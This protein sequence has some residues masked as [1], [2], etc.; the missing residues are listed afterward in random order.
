MHSN[1]PPGRTDEWQVSGDE[2]GAVFDSTRR[3]PAAG[4]GQLPGISLGQARVVGDHE[5]VTR[6]YCSFR[7]AV[8]SLY[9]VLGK[10]P[11]PK[12]SAPSCE[13]CAHE[14]QVDWRLL[15]HGQTSCM[16]ERNDPRRQIF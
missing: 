3:I 8:P 2:S 14:A 6:R 9:P 16:V 4:Q 13:I 5:D 12:K 10:L 11:E 1:F 7:L 15:R